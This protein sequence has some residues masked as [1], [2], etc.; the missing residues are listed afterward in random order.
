MFIKLNIVKKAAVVLQFDN[1]IL[2]IR[3]ARRP[4]REFRQLLY[5]GIETEH[6]VFNMV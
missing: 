3:N 1:L 2:I 5:F 4:Q 6:L